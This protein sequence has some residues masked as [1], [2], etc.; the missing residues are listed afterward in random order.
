MSFMNNMKQTLNQNSFAYTDNG[1]LG[2]STSGTKL[3]DLNFGVTSFRKQQ[4]I[5][6]ENAFAKAFYEDRLMAMKW[7]FYVRDAREGVG[8]RRLFRVAMKWLAKEQPAFAKAVFHLTPLFGRFD[9]MWCL[10]DT[11]LKDSVISEISQLLKTDI[12]ARLPRS[13]YDLWN[14]NLKPYLVE[15]FKKGAVCVKC[16]WCNCYF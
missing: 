13:W 10:L 16:R 9:D 7:L 8:E 2:Y 1:A 3:L 12:E 15:A 14:G 4:D 11:D 5:A 6:I